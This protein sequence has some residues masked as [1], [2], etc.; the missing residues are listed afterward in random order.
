[1]YRSNY[2]GHGHTVQHKIYSKIVECI[3]FYDSN[4]LLIFRRSLVL[5]GSSGSGEESSSFSLLNFAERAL[6]GLFDD[7][8]SRSS[9]VGATL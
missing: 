4:I 7:D 6:L 8:D 2:H 9:S 5:H 3:Q 1:M